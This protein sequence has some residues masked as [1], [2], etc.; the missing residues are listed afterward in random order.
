[1]TLRFLSIIIYLLQNKVTISN[2]FIITPF[3]HHQAL[4]RAL[5]SPH[6]GP[7]VYMRVYPQTYNIDSDTEKVSKYTHM[8]MLLVILFKQFILITSVSNLI[9]FFT[10][11]YFISMYDQGYCIYEVVDHSQKTLSTTFSSSR[12]P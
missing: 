9:T 3:S 10:M 7:I 5:L 1:M 11:V 12:A 6:D 4:L 2:I 8:Y